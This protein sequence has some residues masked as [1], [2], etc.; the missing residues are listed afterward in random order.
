MSPRST[1][2]HRVEHASMP[3][4]SLA[5]CIARAMPRPG[6]QILDLADRDDGHAARR[7]AIEQRLAAR[8]QREIVAVRGSL[9]SAR[10]RRRTAA[11]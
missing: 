11:R 9:E 1:S 4:A 5:V 2:Q 3:S 8:R 10:A 6:E 7:Q